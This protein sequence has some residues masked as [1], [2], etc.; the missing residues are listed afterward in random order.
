MIA[1]KLYTSLSPSGKQRL[2][3]FF[4]TGKD[5]TVPIVAKKKKR[6]CHIKVMIVDEHIGI[7]GNGNQDTQ[8]WYHSQEINVMFD[9]EVVCRGWIDGL[10]R[11]QNTHVY[12][13]VSKEDGI[14]RDGERREAEGV[15]GVDPGRFSWA[16]GVMGAINRVRGTGDF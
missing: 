15:I 7:Q 4:Y 8:S 1:H 16:K 2:H 5:Q 14:W 9:S 12:G 13:E 11:N 6:S 3:Y 10:R